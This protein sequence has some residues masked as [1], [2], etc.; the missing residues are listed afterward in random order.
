MN[1]GGAEGYQMKFYMIGIMAILLLGCLEEIKVDDSCV[2]ID[3]TQ[4]ENVACIL[5]NEK[6]CLCPS[7]DVNV[8]EEC[9]KLN[10]PDRAHPPPLCEEK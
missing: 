3:T 6:L 10:L 5:G 9:D 1:Q 4:Q 8:Q 7:A 2:I